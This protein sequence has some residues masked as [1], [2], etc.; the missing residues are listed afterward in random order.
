MPRVR[1]GLGAEWRKSNYRSQDGDCL[2]VARYLPGLVA[3]RD[4]KE[5]DGVRLVVCREAWQVFIS[6]ALVI[7]HE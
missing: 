5:A 7:A 2:E 1:P 3:V 6:T 4:S